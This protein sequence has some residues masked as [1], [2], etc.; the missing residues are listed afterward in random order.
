MIA[1]MLAAFCVA[2]CG[3]VG[4]TNNTPDGG[5][6]QCSAC[7][8]GFSLDPASVA[9]GACTCVPSWRWIV[10]ATYGT[11]AQRNSAGDTW[12]ALGGLPDPK[13]CMTLG[14][15]R[16]CTPMRADTLSPSWGFSFPATAADTLSGGVMVEYVDED[17]SSDDA[18]CSGQL[19]ISAEAFRTG[20]WGVTCSGLAGTGFSATLAPE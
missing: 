9:S 7:V 6:T 10:T 3:G 2:S 11:V 20:T 12:D 19:S 17:I 1:L 15:V 8:R 18:I 14:G 16:N 4:P 13:V 5:T